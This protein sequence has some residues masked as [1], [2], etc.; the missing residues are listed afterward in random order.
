MNKARQFALTGLIATMG[1]AIP[2]ASTAQKTTPKPKTSTDISIKSRGATGESG[3]TN[4]QP[5]Q[6][7]YNNDSERN[8]IKNDMQS[9]SVGYIHQFNN[10]LYDLHGLGWNGRWSFIP[11]FFYSKSGREELFE[12]PV[13][14]KLACMFDVN[15]GINIVHN[16]KFGIDTRF[17][18]NNPYT[19]PVTQDISAGFNFSQ[20]YLELHSGIPI[21]I[22]KDAP[23]K[24]KPSAFVGLG[25]TPAG[26]NMPVNFYNDTRKGFELKVQIGADVD[27][28]NS[29][30]NGRKG[31]TLGARYMFQNQR[32]SLPWMNTIVPAN[33]LFNPN[34]P[35]IQF[36]LNFDMF[37]GKNKGSGATSSLYQENQHQMVDGDI[38]T[39]PASESTAEITIM[40]QGDTAVLLPKFG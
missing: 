19:G 20:A 37:Q 27:N 38:M 1:W 22:G 34:E 29:V 26:S 39:L 18:Y 12:D 2:M 24:I 14:S 11:S 7:T 4:K 16:G 25:F 10:G 30:N 5:S 33:A 3:K 35:V 31:L 36:Y 8:R 15:L 21:S 13:A 17:N 6:A 9:Y 23:I 28:P 40:K 32:T